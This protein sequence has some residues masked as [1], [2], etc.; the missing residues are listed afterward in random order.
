MQKKYRENQSNVVFVIHF[1]K[2]LLHLILKKTYNRNRFGVIFKVLDIINV[3]EL[4][5]SKD[6]LVCI[7]DLKLDNGDKFRLRMK[8][9]EE[10]RKI[11][12][13]YSIE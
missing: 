3:K 9:T 1:W 12:Y 10:D 13:T 5:R 8:I 7:G 11:W 6:C 2:I 4:S